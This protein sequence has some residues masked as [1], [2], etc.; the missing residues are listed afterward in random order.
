MNKII[1]TI[2]L[3]VLYSCSGVDQ[4]SLPEYKK[5]VNDSNNGLYKKV[6]MDGFE[7]Q[8]V[9][10][11]IEWIVEKSLETSK[12]DETKFDSVRK[13]LDGLQ[14]FG[15]KIINKGIPEIISF[16]ALDNVSYQRNFNYYTGGMKNDIYLVDN[17]DTLP[18]ILFL[19]ER[20]YGA[21]PVNIFNLAFK[22][23]HHKIIEDKDLI[24]D[25]SYMGLGI[26]KFHFKK[27]DLEEIPQLKLN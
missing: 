25:A 17:H 7:L 2:F 10:K 6:E 8:S 12:L 1:Y 3:F 14:Y 27:E 19:Y 15:L 22:N 4:L 11:P 18:C 13:E 21:A 16:N 5:W 26:I 9:Y 24:V 23:K 20:N